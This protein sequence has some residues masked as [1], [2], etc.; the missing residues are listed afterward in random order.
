MLISKRALT[1][2][3]GTKYLVAVSG[4]ILVTFVFF[5]MLGNLQIY[6]GPDALNTY[7]AL[8]KST[9][10]LLWAARLGLLLALAVHV[11]GIASLSLRNRAA[12]A[13]PYRVKR[14]LLSTFASRHMLFTGLVL[15]AFVTYHL[16]HFTVGVTHPDHF[17]LYDS[18]GRHDVYSMVVLGFREP[19]VALSYVIAM[20]LLGLH[21]GHGV[22]SAF[23]SAGLSGPRLRSTFEGL[24]RLLAV[25]IVVGNISIPMACLLGLLQPYNEVF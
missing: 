9:G 11:W 2:T 17:T 8:I 4:A 16:M 20:V 15:L 10:G 13:R 3:V 23:R 19:A 18:Q 14:P 22:G 1:S 5:H 21:L 12:R 7:A 24:G 25:V 6:L